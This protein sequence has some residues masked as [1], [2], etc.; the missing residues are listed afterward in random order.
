MASQSEDEDTKQ[1]EKRSPVII[2]FVS[3]KGGVGKTALAL[4]LAQ[5]LSS[6]NKRVLLM[7]LDLATHGATYF[8]QDKI[9]RNGLHKGI[10]EFIIEQQQKH[11][12]EQQQKHKQGFPFSLDAEF[13]SSELHTVNITENFSFIPSKVEFSMQTFATSGVPEM[14][15]VTIKAFRTGYDFLILD[16]QA[17]ANP[18]AFVA[19]KN[20]DKAIIITEPDPI[21]V[22]ASKNLEYEFRSKTSVGNFPRDTFWILNKILLEEAREYSVLEKYLTIFSHL[23]P[24]PFDFEVRRAFSRR[25]IPLDIDNPSAFFFG[26]TRMTKALLPDLKTTLEESE[27]RQKQRVYGP[28]EEEIKDIDSKISDLRHDLHKPRLRQ[29]IIYPITAFSLFY[30]IYAIVRISGGMKELITGKWIS[31]FIMMFGG[32]FGIM[33]VI[34]WSKWPLRSDLLRR[35]EDEIGRLS[36]ERDRYESLLITKVE[37]LSLGQADPKEH[38]SE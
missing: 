25:R 3:G 38:E 13:I 15:E 19:V 20:S 23:P 26:I 27:S 24:I 10:I 35:L 22:S 4:S 33:A 12:Q 36:A 16:A 17:G 8:F 7:D 18:S 31:A 2:S 1:D 9:E 11:E 32:L 28:I 30:I 29:K 21:C 34:L 6:L 37:E 5:I 14:L